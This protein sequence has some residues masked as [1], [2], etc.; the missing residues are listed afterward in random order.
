MDGPRKIK[1]KSTLNFT[2][3][4]ILLK[5]VCF[6]NLAQTPN[7]CLN[8]LQNF[9]PFKKIINKLFNKINCLNLECV[10]YFINWKRSLIYY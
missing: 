3:Q 1:S 8:K 9:I 7:L 10:I 2:A 5:A 4:T 6:L